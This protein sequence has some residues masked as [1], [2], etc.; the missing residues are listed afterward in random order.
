[1]L[2]GLRAFLAVICVLARKRSCWHRH[3]IWIL[4]HCVVLTDLI[5]KEQSMPGRITDHTRIQVDKWWLF[6]RMRL[7]AQMMVIPVG[8]RR[9]SVDSLLNS[10]SRSSTEEEF[11]EHE[12]AGKAAESTLV[13]VTLRMEELPLLA[14]NKTLWVGARLAGF[15]LKWQKLL[16]DC[17]ASRTC[18]NRVQLEWMTYPPLTQKPLSFSTKNTPKDLQT[19]VDML[20]CKRAV[21]PV[22]KLEIKGSSALSSWCWKTGICVL[23]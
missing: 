15:A 4:L 6:H 19:A 8:H 14:V 1:M 3:L 7:H 20:L 10:D 13:G 11:L 5:C 21:E 23:S 9:G 2:N 18:R 16:G 17:R 22:H 12:E